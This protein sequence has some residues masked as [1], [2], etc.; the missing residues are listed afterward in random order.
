MVESLVSDSLFGTM[1]AIFC[2]NMT[3][4][5]NPVGAVVATFI[6]MIACLL[7]G[8]LNKIAQLSSVLFLLSYT[9]VNLACL[10]LEWASAPN[11]R[12]TF[13]YYSILSSSLGA[14]LCFAMMFV[15]HYVYAIAAVCVFL[16]FALLFNIFGG[17]ANGVWGNIGQA[18]IFHQVRKFLLLLD[19]RKEHVKFWRPQILLLVSNPRYNCQLISFVNCLKKSGLLI[20]GKFNLWRENSNYRFCFNR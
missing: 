7:I 12:P 3:I 16:I 17:A 20:L 4:G 18:L 9:T 19:P 10:F 5:N 8:S 2:E 15:I 1:P 11:F 13:K 14:I 6:L